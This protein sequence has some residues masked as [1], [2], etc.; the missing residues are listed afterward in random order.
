[1]KYVCLS[2]LVAGLLFTASTS[3]AQLPELPLPSS[4]SGNETTAQFYGGATADNGVT[5][6]SSFAFDQAID[7]ETE[8]RIEQAHLNTVGN[9][10]IIIAW[11]E[12]FFM[13]DDLGAY[14]VWDLTLENLLEGCRLD[15]RDWRFAKAWLS[16]A[17]GLASP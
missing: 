5:Y 6:A 11:E 12:L 16:E 8:I 13:R 4:A 17:V 10:Y 14:Q 1:M 7:I 9:L 3:F 15:L 2:T